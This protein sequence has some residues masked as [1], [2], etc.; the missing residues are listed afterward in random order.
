MSL[1][2][3]Y[4]L[5]GGAGAL[6]LPPSELLHLNQAGVQDLI[7]DLTYAHGLKARGRCLH[8]TPIVFILFLLFEVGGLLRWFSI[9]QSLEQ[10]YP[11]A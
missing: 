11:P 9:Y 6:P 3:L 8:N 5:M 7:C 4:V 2:L 10:A 1:K